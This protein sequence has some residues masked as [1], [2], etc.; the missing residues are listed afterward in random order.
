LWAFALGAATATLGAAVWAKVALSLP[1]SDVNLMAIL[2]GYAIGAATALA[3]PSSRRV[4]PKV[5]A[6]LLTL[7]GV[8]FAQY[9][10]DRWGV[11]A[12]YRRYSWWVPHAHLTSGSAWPAGWVRMV[13]EF[14]DHQNLLVS[15]H[16]YDIL[17]W[18]LAVVAAGWGTRLT[19]GRERTSEA[20]T[21]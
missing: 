16:R 2:V 5:L 17:F 9:L 12:V 6:G 18:V 11:E 4:A 20:A 8:F 13:W 15:S 14:R 7:W 1:K 19:D 10:I 21:A 3:T